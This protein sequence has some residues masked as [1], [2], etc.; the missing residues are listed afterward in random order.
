MDRMENLRRTHYCAEIPL[1]PCE[2]V[3]GGFAQEA[4]G[5]KTGVVHVLARLRLNHLHHRADDMTLGVELTGVARRVGGHAL[6]QV[7]INFRQNDDVGFAGEMQLVDLPVG[8]PGPGEVRIRHHAIG[9]NFLDVYQRAG[10]YPLPLPLSLG[11]EG[12][13]VIEAVGPG[14]AHLKAGDRA[15]YCG[16]PPGAYS[17]ARVMP[18]RVAQSSASRSA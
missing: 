16:G 3:V 5:A 12:A 13:G 8:E 2:V 4:S 1:T 11:N 6:E 7:F 15:V 14:V 9:L 17:L 18:A 10:V